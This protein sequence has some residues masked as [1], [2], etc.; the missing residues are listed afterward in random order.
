MNLTDVI[1]LI[2]KGEGLKLEFKEAKG[3]VPASFYETVV[4]FA[5]T[6]GGTVLFG[7]DDDGEVTGVQPDLSLKIQKDIV[8]ALNSRDCID[9]P[10][11]IQPYSV[12][13]WARI[14][15]MDLRRNRCL[16]CTGCFLV[17]D[18]QIYFFYP[19]DASENSVPAEKSEDSAHNNPHSG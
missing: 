12:R 7:I 11:H 6:D 14:I 4:A 16:S 10:M 18:C 19:D 2:K 17:F 3:S 8:T 13:E 9:P 15:S 5:N 1:T